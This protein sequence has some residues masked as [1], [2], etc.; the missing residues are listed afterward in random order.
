M[1]DVFGRVSHMNFRQVLSSTIFKYI[2]FFSQQSTPTCY[3]RI[4][5][6]GSRYLLGDLDGRLFMLLL[7]QQTV[8]GGA[9]VKE[10]KLETLGEV[11]CGN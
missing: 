11:K 8:D 4:D 5:P 10:L 7:E 2:I 1:Y 6:N 3:G 9:V